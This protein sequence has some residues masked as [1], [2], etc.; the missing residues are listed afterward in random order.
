[1][2]RMENGLVEPSEQCWHSLQKVVRY[3]KLPLGS[4]CNG[5][6]CN[7]L[8]S[9]PLSM[10]SFFLLIK[11]RPFHGKG[12]TA[13]NL[14]HFFFPVQAWSRLFPTLPCSVSTFWVFTFKIPDFTD[15]MAFSTQF[16]FHTH[17]WTHT[18]TCVSCLASSAGVPYEDDSGV[19]R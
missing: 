16:S 15:F 19:L 18:S 5:H 9:S 10:F 2:P 8:S 17:A 6:H 1:M 14:H 12:G 3:S 13:L 4:H 11:V 7:G